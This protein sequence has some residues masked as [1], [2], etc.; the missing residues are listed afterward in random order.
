VSELSDELKKFIGKELFIDLIGK[1]FAPKGT[2]TEVN[3]EFI[4]LGENHIVIS[5]IASFKLIKG[6]NNGR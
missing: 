6:E 5:S 4:I 2:L 3:K 1:N